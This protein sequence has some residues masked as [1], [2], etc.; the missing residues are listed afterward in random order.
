MCVS[1][2]VTF[3]TGSIFKPFQ[4]CD[5]AGQQID[6]GSGTAGVPDALVS[7]IKPGD[8]VTAMNGKT[9]EVNIHRAEEYVNAYACSMDCLD[10]CG[11]CVGQCRI[12][13]DMHGV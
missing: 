1:T 7:A 6:A 10:V 8:V 4:G 9:I 12:H 13:R 11:Q 3:H 5:R 2:G